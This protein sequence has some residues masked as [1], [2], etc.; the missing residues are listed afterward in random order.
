LPYLHLIPLL[1]G[2]HDVTGRKCRRQTVMVYMRLSY[3]PPT[4]AVKNLPTAHSGTQNT[5]TWFDFQ[6]GAGKD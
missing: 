4:S 2:K 6:S 5:F 1:Q 3:A